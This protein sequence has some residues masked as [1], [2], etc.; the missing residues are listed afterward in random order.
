MLLLM[1]HCLGIHI[2]E[3]MIKIWIDV[4]VLV[5]F[6]EFGEL[7]K[8]EVDFHVQCVFEYSYELCDL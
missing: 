4:G 8:S 3:L 2:H 6:E 5:Y 7:A 1:N